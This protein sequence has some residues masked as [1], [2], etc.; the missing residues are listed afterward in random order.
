MERYQA[1]L[2]ELREGRLD[3]A[4]FRREAFGAGLILEEDG[5]WIF[6]L[7]HS[8]WLHYDGVEI[9]AVSRPAAESGSP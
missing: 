8:R 1:L 2:S 5:A 9:Q 6:D 4:A 7:E 3:H